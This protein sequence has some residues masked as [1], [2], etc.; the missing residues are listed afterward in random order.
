YYKTSNG[1]EGAAIM[2]ELYDVSWKRGEKLILQQLNWSVKE[3]EHWCILGLNGSGKT[4][5]LEMLNGYIWPTT[6]TISVLGHRFGE[7]DLRELRKSIG[8]VS[9]AMQQRFYDTDQALQIVLSG[10]FASIGI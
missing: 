9:T 1:L 3:K 7:Y 5:L 6:G 10:K 4:T 8:W 2:I